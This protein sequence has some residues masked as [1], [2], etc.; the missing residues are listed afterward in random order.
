MWSR[1]LLLLLP[2]LRLLRCCRAFR[3]GVAASMSVWEVPVS[4]GMGVATRAG[5]PAPLRAHVAEPRAALTAAHHGAPGPPLDA[6]LPA[7]ACH[8]QP[9]T[10]NQ[11]GL[12]A[13]V[14]YP[15]AVPPA[16]LAC[17]FRRALLLAFRAQQGLLDSLVFPRY[18]W[19]HMA[20]LSFDRVAWDALGAVPSHAGPGHAWSTSTALMV[21]GRV[22]VTALR[23][24]SASLA[25]SCVRPPAVAFDT[26]DQWFVGVFRM[27]AGVEARVGTV[28][29]CKAFR[30][31]WRDASV[32]AR[33]AVPAFAPQALPWLRELVP[34]SVPPGLAPVSDVAGLV[35]AYCAVVVSAGPPRRHGRCTGDT[36]A[37][38]RGQQ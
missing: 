28:G 19:T 2:S 18:V 29:A 20:A 8:V 17:L 9:P 33:L 24:L 14:G 15:T 10:V 5:P 11:L 25:A 36:R 16:A 26:W 32:P 4:A 30:R 13:V 22:F 7:Y 21:L 34:A 23:A 35:S 31:L 38:P 27:L 1:L 6:P 12:A 37:T 3:R